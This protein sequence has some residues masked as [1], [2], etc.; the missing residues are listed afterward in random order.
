[1]P[2]TTAGPKWS[3]L[4]LC[5]L[6]LPLSPEHRLF[7][8]L[9][10]YSII[11]VT[12]LESIPA[13]WSPSLLF[14]MYKCLIEDLLV[15]LFS[16]WTLRARPGTVTSLLVQKNLR[17][18]TR[19]ISE[20]T[21]HWFQKLKNMLLA[22]VMKFKFPIIAIFTRCSTRMP[23][24]IWQFI[25][26]F[27]LFEYVFGIVQPS[28]DDQ[29]VTQASNILTNSYSRDLR[30]DRTRELSHSRQWISTVSFYLVIVELISEA[31]L[32]YIIYEVIRHKLSDTLQIATNLNRFSE[33]PEHT[34]YYV[35]RRSHVATSPIPLHLK[36]S[37]IFRWSF[38]FTC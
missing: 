23:W 29:S 1:M 14:I 17:W 9:R 7:G 2:C 10:N 11:T 12:L 34:R 22:T 32:I 26:S 6:R 31:L 8:D 15:R 16:H 18:V 28:Q 21:R 33:R 19:T 38:F 13:R 35:K 36:V 3:M 24:Q 37:G 5:L 20:L 27:N 4:W 25:G 30:F